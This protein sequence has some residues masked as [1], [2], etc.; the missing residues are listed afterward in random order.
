MVYDIMGW[1]PRTILAAVLKIH[2]QKMFRACSRIVPRSAKVIQRLLQVHQHT[3]LFCDFNNIG[4][5]QTVQIG[6]GYADVFV[7]Q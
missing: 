7:P 6:L 2:I 4:V 3:L 5:A 1:Q